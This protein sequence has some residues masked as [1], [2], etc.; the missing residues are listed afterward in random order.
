VHLGVYDHPVKNGEY[1][2]FKNRSRTLLAE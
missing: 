1:Q 2:D